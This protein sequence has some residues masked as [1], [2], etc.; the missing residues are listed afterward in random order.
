MNT[1]TAK[2]CAVALTGFYYLVGC[3]N[4]SPS[5]I[6]QEPAADAATAARIKTALIE[7]PDLDAAAINVDV[8]AGVVQLKGFVE[9]EA[10]RRQAANAAKNIPGVGQ[11]KND[12]E[13]K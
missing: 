2:F 8:T 5:E 10:Q 12:I 9:T 3:A 4:H 6:E 11:V 13:V 1:R 7:D